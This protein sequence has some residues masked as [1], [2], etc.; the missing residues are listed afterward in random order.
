MSFGFG[1][2]GRAFRQARGKIDLVSVADVPLTTMKAHELDVR[3]PPVEPDEKSRFRD[4]TASIW[5]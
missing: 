1:V 5:P 4:K 2:G 3:N